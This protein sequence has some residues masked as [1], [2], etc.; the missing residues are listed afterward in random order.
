MTFPRRARWAFLCCL[1]AASLCFWNA[2][3]YDWAQGD[4]SERL[5]AGERRDRHRR[6]SREWVCQSL[7]WWELGEAG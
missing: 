1:E 7:V 2:D 6:L 3:H 4:V 5:F